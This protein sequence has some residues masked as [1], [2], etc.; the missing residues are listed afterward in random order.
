MVNVLCLSM[1]RIQ[2]YSNENQNRRTKLM[3]EDDLWTLGEMGDH[4]R[5]F[6][7]PDVTHYFCL[8]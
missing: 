6:T 3:R 7:M 4:L 2:S 5:C 1:L 8:F